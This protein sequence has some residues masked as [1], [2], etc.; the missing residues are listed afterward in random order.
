MP[1]Q[2]DSGFTKESLVFF[3][4][5][6][7]RKLV[8][9][10]L[11]SWLFSQ[12]AAILLIINCEYIMIFQSFSRLQC[13]SERHFDSH[14]ICI[15]QT[16]WIAEFDAYFHIPRLSVLLVTLALQGINAGASVCSEKQ[17]DSRSISSPP[18]IPSVSIVFFFC[19]A[20]PPSRPWPTPVFHQTATLSSHPFAALS[21]LCDDLIPCLSLAPPWPSP[22]VSLPADHHFHCTIPLYK[23]CNHIDPK[24]DG[25]RWSVNTRVLNNGRSVLLRGDGRMG[26]VRDAGGVVQAQPVL[27]LYLI[28]CC[29]RGEGVGAGKVFVNW[30]HLSDV[31]LSCLIGG[32]HHWPS[33]GPASLPK[34]CSHLYN[35]HSF[36]KLCS[37]NAIKR[38]QLR[39]SRWKVWHFTLTDDEIGVTGQTGS[40]RQG[41]GFIFA[42]YALL[43]FLHQAH[44]L[45]SLLS[46]FTHF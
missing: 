22:H 9:T 45:S 19:S 6:L 15:M 18:F 13:F 31:L 28:C 8:K 39:V 43:Q 32:C 3:R 30:H 42:R 34:P 11:L 26:Y 12:S 20:P 37:T 23:K 38:L 27:E 35:C 25:K 36:I 10:N 17:A 1:T 4:Q 7:V 2:R 46:H 44:L 40:F 33:P 29:E 41:Y 14:F 16:C 21:R 24:L 5:Q